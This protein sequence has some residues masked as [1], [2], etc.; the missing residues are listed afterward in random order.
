MLGEARPL[1][2]DL[3]FGRREVLAVSFDGGTRPR[4]VLG[5]P[6]E[7]ES[8]RVVYRFSAPAAWPTRERRATQ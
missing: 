7:Q 4:R 1:V 8:G 6:G 2:V 3:V 5:D